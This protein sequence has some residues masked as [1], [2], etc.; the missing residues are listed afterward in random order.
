VNLLKSE[1]EKLKGLLKKYDY[2][3]MNRAIIQVADK[4]NPMPMINTAIT[5]FFER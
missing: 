4:I 1:L 5:K 2:S 3:L